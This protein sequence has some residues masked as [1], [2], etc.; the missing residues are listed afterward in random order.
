MYFLPLEAPRRA[1]RRRGTRR[2]VHNT[3][4]STPLQAS[5]FSHLLAVSTLHVTYFAVAVE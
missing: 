2:R 3:I 4:L 1:R 5:N